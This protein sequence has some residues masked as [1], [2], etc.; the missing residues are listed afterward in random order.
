[1]RIL[2]YQAKF[3]LR[4][5][6]IPIPPGFVASHSKSPLRLP[7]CMA[8]P[9]IVKAQ[10][11]AGSRNE[12]G[13]VRIAATPEEAE[14]AISCLL[15]GRFESA[16]GSSLPIRRVLVERLEDAVAEA[17]ASVALDRDS[18]AV[19]LLTSASGGTAVESSGRVRRTPLVLRDRERGLEPDLALA[20]AA[21]FGWPRE[22]T[23]RA[24]DLLRRLAGVFFRHECVL[25]EVNPLGLTRDGRVVALDAKMEVDDYALFR[26]PEVTALASPG[27]PA[28]GAGLFGADEREGPETAG[29]RAAGAPD[30]DRGRDRSAAADLSESGGGR[31]PFVRLGGR[32]GL[33]ANGA[34]LA[35]ATADALAAAGRPAASFC[36]IGGAATPEDAA[37]AVTAVL[38]DSAPPI[39]LV[40]VF[41]G[42][43]RCDAVAEGVVRA[44]SGSVRKPR[45][46]VRFEGNRKDEGLAVLTAS[47]LDF[48]VAESFEEAV[49]LAAEAG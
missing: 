14:S 49:R 44:L 28:E 12:A 36:D 48:R 7:K 35:M 2:E 31:I 6:G 42:I 11:A 47:G 34:G 5:A 9:V 1:M 27:H 46:V 17:Y 39:L 13:A 19:I 18:S 8:P 33:I 40:H 4:Q 23:E 22:A 45:C 25:A 26:H 32:V 24:A 16:D 10:V 43:V 29:A 38:D 37:R 21:G 20:A 41:G 30:P 3:L 15:N